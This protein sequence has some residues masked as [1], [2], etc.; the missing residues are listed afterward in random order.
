MEQWKDL[1]YQ[2]KNYGERLEISTKGRIRNKL[3]GHIYK[4]HKNKNGYLCVCISLGSR[5][6]KISFRVHKAVA[7][8]FIPNPKKLPEVNHLNGNK[9]ENFTWNLEWVSGKENMRHA[10]V[11]GIQK[12][13]RGIVNGNSTLSQKD[14][15]YIRNNYKER[16]KNFGCRALAKKF[17]V[18]HSTISRIINGETY[19]YK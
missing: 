5:K 13:P 2:G 14:I 10:V 19:K 18:N 11:M 6:D 16:D 9:E 8:T 4:L 15:N 7:E 1:I 3:N 17:N 12:A